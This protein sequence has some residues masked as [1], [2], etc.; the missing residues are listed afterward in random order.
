MY[1]IFSNSI[2]KSTSTRWTTNRPRKNTCMEII[3]ISRGRN[4]KTCIFS[5]S[6][7]PSSSQCLKA[8]YSVT[9]H[10]IHG[11]QSLCWNIPIF[12]DHF[13]LTIWFSRD[14]S[15]FIR[16]PVCIY[17]SSSRCLDDRHIKCLSI[18]LMMLLV[19]LPPYQ[20]GCSLLPY[21]ETGHDP[22]YCQIQQGYNK[23]QMNGQHNKWPH[24]TLEQTNI[25]AP[26]CMMVQIFLI[27]L[28]CVSW[29]TAVYK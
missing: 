1:H 23:P 15:M 5:T 17:M 8:Y 16:G 9:I 4:M 2:G 22:A 28:S 11:S 29:N 20:N 7:H 12:F 6:H 27:H 13:I 25:T 21:M 26:V 24:R 10:S 3:Q 18:Y 14:Q 19:T